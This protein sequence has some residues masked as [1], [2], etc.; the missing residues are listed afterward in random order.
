[1]EEF[2]ASTYGNCD[3]QAAPHFCP[4]FYLGDD[5]IGRI[6]CKHCLIKRQRG[7]KIDLKFNLDLSNSFNRSS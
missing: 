5:L 1:M 4:L 2:I 6:W 7:R 3:Q